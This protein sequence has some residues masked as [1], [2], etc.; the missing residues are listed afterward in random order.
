MGWKE[1]SILRTKNLITCSIL[2]SIFDISNKLQISKVYNLFSKKSGL[3]NRSLGQ[4]SS[5]NLHFLF[6]YI[7]LISILKI[8]ITKLSKDKDL[9]QG[10]LFQRCAH[11]LCCSVLSLGGNVNAR[12][13][14]KPDMGSIFQIKNQGNILV[15]G[16]Y[17][18]NYQNYQNLMLLTFSDTKRTLMH[19]LLPSLFFL[20]PSPLDLFCSP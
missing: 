17:Y 7:L 1:I 20:P 18:V 2:Q 16:N 9:M 19:L 12:R 10:K 11:L 8:F 6:I 15:I 14:S 13:M 3:K 4:D 5:S